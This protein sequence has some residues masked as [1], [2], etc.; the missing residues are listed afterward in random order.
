MVADAASAAYF[1]RRA[2]HMCIDPNGETRVYGAGTSE[3]IDKVC[4]EQFNGE[5]EVYKGYGLERLVTLRYVDADG[6]PGAVAV[7]LSRFTTPEGAYGFFTRRIIGGADPAERAPEVLAAGAAAAIGA[8]PAAVVRGNHV[9]ELTY[10]NEREPTDRV[11]EL[12]RRAL[13]PIAVEMGRRLPGDLALP[14]AARALPEAGRLRLGIA[15]EIRDLLG[16]PGAGGGAVGYYRDGDKRWR[17]ACAVRPDEAGAA[18]VIG[19]LAKALGAKAE[20]GTVFRALRFTLAIEGAGGKLEWVMARAGARVYAVGDE[21]YVAGGDRP[22]EEVAK[23]S[24][25]LAQKLEILGK[26]VSGE[27]E[28]AR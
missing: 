17:V 10:T 7:N 21:E 2:G 24:L 20:K 26:L 16:V 8:G 5:C 13:P 1:P 12:A 11:G 15:Y 23:G 4:L 25:S 27:P 19:T 6:S 3:S 18:D 14:A 22:A 9:V 28:I